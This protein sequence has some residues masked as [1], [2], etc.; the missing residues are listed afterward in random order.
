MTARC[1]SRHDWWT[2]CGHGST[3]TTRAGRSVVPDPERSAAGA[4]ELVPI[5]HRA[6]RT[7][8][9]PPADLACRHA[10]ATTWLRAG[11]PLGEVA[12]AWATAS[13]L[14]CPPTS[15]RSRATSG[16][17]QAHRRRVFD[18][19][20]ADRRQR[21]EVSPVLVPWGQAKPGRNGLYAVIRGQGG[22]LGRCPG[23][24]ADRAAPSAGIRTCA[25]GSGGHQYIA[26]QRLVGVGAA[27]PAN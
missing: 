3:S 18:R 13:R 8:G 11:V 16:G 19:P 1:R 27:M 12:A 17:E 15:V 21:P 7:V 14:W 22:D 25:H 10:A 26:A 6:Y 2:C 23:H 5:L 24:S 9:H 20:R 4:L